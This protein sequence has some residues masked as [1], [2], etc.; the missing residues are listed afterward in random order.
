MN[1]NEKYLNWLEGYLRETIEKALEQAF[2]DLQ[3][4]DE[5]T[6]CTLMSLID[7]FIKNQ[8]N[9]LEGKQR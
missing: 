8:L 3:I 9:L 1:A 6:K 2:K 4:D 5:D 7:G